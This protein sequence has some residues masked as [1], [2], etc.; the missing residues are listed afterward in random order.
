[1]TDP[2]RS[3]TT[4]ALVAALD[5]VPDPLGRGGLVAAGRAQPPALRNGI[6]DVILDVSGLAADSHGALEQAVRAALAAV[7]GVDT[8]RV[9]MTAERRERRILAVASGKGG[10]GK[11][12]LAANLAIAL[13]RSG[14]RVGLVDAD[15]YGPSQPRL[16]AAEGMKPQAEGQQLIPV[17]T[18]Y[19]VPMLSMGQLVDPGQAIAW[20]GPMAASALGQLVDARWGDTDLLVVDMPPGTGDVQLTMIQKHRPA[21]ALIVSTP[22]DL[23]LIDATRAIDLFGKA[24][25]P[26]MGLVENM[27]GYRCPAC[28]TVSDPF[29]SGGA[30]EEARARGIP[31]LG[32]VP[33]AIGIRRASDAGNPPAAG[34]GAEAEPFAAIA[35]AV[36][37]W[38]NPSPR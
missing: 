22:Q 32:R 15:I 34:E 20:R 6:V 9:A 35:A 8:V 17:A 12:T 30:E 36:A 29:G 31:F 1:M 24:G 4:Q 26:I 10:V 27:A 23:A 16:M 28:G 3:A 11:S 19:G 5:R 25:V 37:A 38:A 7:P 2:D 21:A 18:R 33:L 14:L 13:A